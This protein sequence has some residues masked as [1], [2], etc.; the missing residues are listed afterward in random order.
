ML[1]PNIPPTGAGDTRLPNSVF[2]PTW[3]VNLVKAITK[4]LNAWLAN[5]EIT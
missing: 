2:F 4:S 3:L 5:I 1:D